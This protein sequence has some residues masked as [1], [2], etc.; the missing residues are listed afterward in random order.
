M[1]R[2]SARNA[3][4]VRSTSSGVAESS[5]AASPVSIVNAEIAERHAEVLRGHVFELVRLV[6]D[7]RGAG[8][9]DFAVRALPHGCVSAQQMV[10]DDDDVGFGGTL[11]H[12]REEA[13]AV[14][15]AFGAEAGVRIGG[16]L[17][18]EG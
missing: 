11:T 9:D 8:G 10:V 14:A 6:H 5:L 15:G 13:V 12:Q 4:S 3:S 18:P 2:V 17:F 16:D 7:E 1:I